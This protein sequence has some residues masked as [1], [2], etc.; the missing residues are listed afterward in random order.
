MQQPPD[1]GDSETVPFALVSRDDVFHSQCN[2]FPSL[3]VSIAHSLSALVLEC[4]F[5][6]F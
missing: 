1:D 3:S 4:W 5:E 6:G 2:N